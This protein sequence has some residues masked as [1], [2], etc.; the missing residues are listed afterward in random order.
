MHLKKRLT[1][2]EN[3]KVITEAFTKLA[4]IGD[5]I[6]NDCVDYFL[7]NFPETYNVLVTDY[8]G[9]QYESAEYGNHKRR[10]IHMEQKLCLLRI[11]AVNEDFNAITLSNV[12]SH[13]A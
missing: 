4:G 9:N 6:K 10:L 1:L 3:I 5:N 12:W 8:I 11:K 2:Q 13:P 7:A